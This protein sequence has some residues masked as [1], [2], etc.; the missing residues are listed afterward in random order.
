M[1]E[2]VASA[3]VAASGR[4]RKPSRRPTGWPSTST[5]PAAVT[6]LISSSPLFR[7]RVS[8]AWRRSTKRWVS[9]WCSASDR[10]SSIGA[11][12]LLP[13]LGILRA[14]RRGGRCRSRCGYGRCAAPACRCRRRCGRCGRSGR[15]PSRRQHAA[16]T[17][18][19]AEDLRQQAGVGV[20]QDLAEVRDLAD[21]P[22]QAQGRAR[23]A[24]GRRSRDRAPGSRSAAGRRPR[25]RASGRAPAAAARGCAAGRRASGSRDRRCARTGRPA[26]RSGGS[27]SPR[28]VSGSSGPTSVVVPK[29]PSFMWR[30]ARPAICAISGAV[31]RRGARPSNLHQ[32]GEGDVVDVHVEAHADGVGGDQVVDLAGLVHRDLGVAG[33]RATARPSRRR[34]RRAGGASARRSR[35]RRRPRRRRRR[36][37]RGRR[38]SFFGAGIGERGEARP[39]DDLGLR[40]QPRSSGRMVSAPRNMVSSAPRACSRRSVKTWPRSGSAASWISSTA[41]KST[42]R[43]TGI[44]STVQTK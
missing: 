11:R 33:A 6:A 43:S 17:R 3:P 22:Q 28:P 21:L 30:P 16:R 26:D 18:Q 31:R 10:R 44:D 4:K 1:S 38:V 37:A 39:R 5:S 12:A 42:R 7:R 8:T 19:V 32:L 34:S 41:R 2:R 24:R 36:C 15:R 13:V 20:A 27:R 35:R 9:D 23:A 29:L 25:A 40:H 14:S